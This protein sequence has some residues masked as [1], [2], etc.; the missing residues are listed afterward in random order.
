MGRCWRRGAPSV[1]PRRSTSGRCFLDPLLAGLD[2]AAHL[3]ED[4]FKSKVAFVVLLNW[5]QTT[6]AERAEQGPGWS[7]SQ[8]AE[9]RLAGRFARRVPGE[10]RREIARVASEADL[11]ISEYNLRMHHVLDAEGR[12]LFPKGKRLISHWNLRDELKAAYADAENG[13]ARQ[14]T[15]TRVMERIVTQT[16]PAAVI[17]NPRLDWNPFTNEVVPAP[18]ETVEESAPESTPT[19]AP[20]PGRED[21]VRYARL[22]AQFHAARRADPYSPTAPTQI[23]RVFELQ[24]ELPEARVE[25]LFTQVLTSPLVEQV[26][27]EAC[28]RLGRPLEPQDLWYDGFKARAPSPRP[29]LDAI[30]PQALPDGAGLRAPTSRAS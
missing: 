26:A 19:T 30:D 8:W 14:R 5:P 6:L 25:A 27:A 1:G 21:D 9:A 12:R 17:D 29:A 13:V 23:K 11:Y 16:I 18:A 4:L 24:R 2:P 10:V 15:I 20:S 28:R 7:R 3:N 22:L